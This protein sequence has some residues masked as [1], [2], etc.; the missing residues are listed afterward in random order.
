VLPPPGAPL[1]GAAGT[2]ERAAEAVVGGGGQ[3]QQQQQQQ[4]SPSAPPGTHVGTVKSFNPAKGFGFITSQTVE[5]DL[6]FLRTELPA[7]LH[8][9]EGSVLQGR[10]VSFEVQV[11]PE[12]RC[13]AAGIRILPGEGELITGVIKSYSERHGYGFVSTACFGRD[14]HFK[15]HDLPPCL[16]GLG[17]DGLLGRHVAFRVEALR[18]GKLKALQLQVADAPE[19]AP[20]RPAAGLRQVL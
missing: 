11:T 16:Q 15:S 19:A 13:R 18:D 12:G 10:S 4:P 14:V 8:S 3:R 9:G 7:E 17:I 20:P 6:F 5:G 2:T 1:Q